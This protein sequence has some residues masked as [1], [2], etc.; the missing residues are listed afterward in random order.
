MIA[1]IAERAA[2]RIGRKLSVLY[3]GSVDRGNAA[4]LAAEP[5]IDGLFIGRSAWDA[6]GLLAIARLFADV[7]DL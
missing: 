4:A 1:G 5:D 7:R 3:G 6:A 2:S